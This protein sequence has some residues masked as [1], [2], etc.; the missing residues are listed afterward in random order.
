MADDAFECVK[1]TH[2]SA[3]ELQI[4]LTVVILLILISSGSFGITTNL[5]NEIKALNIC[6]RK[7]AHAN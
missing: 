7:S 3:H 6:N 1:T 5:L 4:L 2:Q